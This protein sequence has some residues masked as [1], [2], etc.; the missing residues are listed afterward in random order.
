MPNAAT[1]PKSK[2]KLKYTYD[3]CGTMTKPCD[4][5]EFTSPLSLD[6]TF[7]STHIGDNVKSRMELY[8]HKDGTGIIEWTVKKLDMREDIGLKFEYAPDG[9]RTLSEYSGVFSIPEQAMDLLERNGVDVS[10]M[11]RLMR[12]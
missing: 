7:S 12:K 10:E 4:V 6:R 8:L 9:K 1:K 11:R 5:Y 2:T 3:P